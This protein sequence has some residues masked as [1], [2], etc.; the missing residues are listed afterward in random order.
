MFSPPDYSSEI[1]FLRPRI[2]P[3]TVLMGIHRK[4][5]L[6]SLRDATPMLKGRLLDVGCGNKP[7]ATILNCDEHVGIDVALS[8]HNQS[9]FDRVFDGLT[10]PFG[11]ATF[12]SVLCTEVLEHAREPRKLAT[13][14]GRVLK[15][16][17]YAFWTVP[18][19]FPH[20]EQ[21]YDFHRF[22]RYG[23]EELA[24]TAGLSIVTIQNRG[25]VLALLAQQIDIAIGQL[26]SRRPFSDAVRWL[27]FP[28]MA[29]CL[30]L[31]RWRGRPDVLTP[32]WQLLLRKP[33]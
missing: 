20:H 19:V 21:P 10:I 16:G 22:T 30:V 15:P 25:G 9:R 6:S 32:G 26:L 29:F 2:G 24:T 8:P 12:D 31:D 33:A 14:I 23:I 18:F 5:I 3:W 4:P 17:G 27:A 13:E 1:S 11:D 28:I 7:Y